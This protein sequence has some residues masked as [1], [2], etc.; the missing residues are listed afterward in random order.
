[1]NLF[2]EDSKI[3]SN[4]ITDKAWWTLPSSAN[5]NKLREVIINGTGSPKSIWKGAIKPVQSSLNQF[6]S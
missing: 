6:I 2:F 1:M 3:M 5:F 4:F